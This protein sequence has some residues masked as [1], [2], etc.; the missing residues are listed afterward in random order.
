MKFTK[1][2]QCKLGAN[3]S[4]IKQRRFYLPDSTVSFVLSYF[5][6][7]LK[8]LLSLQASSILLKNTN[9]HHQNQACISILCI[10]TSRRN[11]TKDN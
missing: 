6:P 9:K 4:R 7:A 10:Y 5:S 2:L 8:G 1:L 3:K 11:S